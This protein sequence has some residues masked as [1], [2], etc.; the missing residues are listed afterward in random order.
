M[1][2]S[3]DGIRFVKA[4]PNPF[5]S[6][7]A[8][9]RPGPFRDPVVFRDEASGTY[10]MLVTA[11]LADYPLPGY[12]GCLAHLT[13]GPGEWRQEGPFIVPGYAGH[14]PECADI[15]EWHGWH[16]LIFSH[17][18]V[19]HYRM[20]RSPFGPWQCP[21]Q[22]TFDGAQAIVMK[23]AAWTDDR[24]LSV[25]FLASPRPNSYAGNAVFREIIQHADGTLG[26]RFPPE[27]MPVAADRLPPVFS[28]LAGEVYQEGGSVTVDAREGLAVVCM[29]SSPRDLR[30][31]ARVLP[32]PGT[33]GFEIGFRGSGAYEE[34]HLLRFE[35]ARGRVGWTRPGGGAGSVYRPADAEEQ[36]RAAIYGV[37]G[38]DR[39]FDLDIV[40]KD[41]IADV[42]IDG[43]R[44]LIVRLPRLEG[45]RLFLMCRDGQVTFEAL[46][47]DRIAG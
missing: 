43:R 31:T 10:H 5:A 6:P 44:T 46:T 18:G 42:C 7:E 14:Q 4:E 30:L 27:M 11:E 22:D 45:D 21:A 3:D 15:F 39:P 17:L 25:A 12:G 35:P 26:T 16:Y 2:T 19:A 28:A 34:G 9:Y 32:E 20:A 40:L 37:T 1:A 29:E 36:E 23:T 47:V 8:P 33:G 41:D 24:R 38:L 13:G